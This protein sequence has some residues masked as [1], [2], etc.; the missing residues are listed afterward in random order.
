MRSDGPPEISVEDHCLGNVR[1]LFD[2]LRRYEAGGETAPE[3]LG[4]AFWRRV[5][6]REC[7]ST[8]LCCPAAQQ[9]GLKRNS[10]YRGPSKRWS[11]LSDSAIVLADLPGNH[12]G[13]LT[14]LRKNGEI[15]FALVG[16]PLYDQA[17][18]ETRE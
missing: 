5:A 11:L 4:G 6:D 12:E 15:L 8:A 17:L 18:A 14:L 7:V 16:S 3:V 9:A 2:A 10:C 13:G 1:L